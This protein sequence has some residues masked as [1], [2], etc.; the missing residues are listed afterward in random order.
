MISFT[1]LTDT[2]I[3]LRD[4]LIAR[5]IIMQTPQGLTG[6]RRGVEWVEVPNIIVTTL[7]VGTRGQPGYV[8][9][10]MDPRRCWL[11]KLAW[12]AEANEKEGGDGSILQTKFGQWVMNNSV[13]D[14]LTSADGRSWPARRVGT[15][16]WLTISDDFGV[17]QR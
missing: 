9:R 14:T 8:P 17:W 2:P 5:D 10:G 11:V 3:R 12:E 15:N 6:V 1:I 16:F 13:A 4:Q 7:A